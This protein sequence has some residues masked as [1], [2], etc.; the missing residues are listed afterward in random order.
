MT[1][2]VPGGSIQDQ[3]DELIKSKS[4]LLQY[5]T[6]ITRD[7]IPKPIHSHNDCMLVSLMRSTQSLIYGG[8]D[9][10]Q[11]P[12]FTALGYGCMSVE[13]DV[14]WLDELLWVRFVL[15]S[16]ILISILLIR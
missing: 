14:W 4:S 16:D 9:W 15:G 6:S 3:I 10:R 8:E 2:P 11:V 12:L 5:P 1:L 7:I 13:A